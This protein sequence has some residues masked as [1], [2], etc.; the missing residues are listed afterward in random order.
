MQIRVREDSVEIEGYVN[1]VERNSKPLWSRI[2]Q[3]IERICAGAFKK[4]MERREDVHILLNHDP[5]RDLGSVA[6]GNLELEEDNIG[7]R[8]RATITDAEVVEEARNG[9]LVGWSFG[10][11]DVPDGVDESMR[12]PETNLPMRVVRDLDLQ[13]VSILDRR[14]TPAYN[15]TLIMARAEDAPVYYGEEQEEDPEI[16]EERA[17]SAAEDVKPEDAPEDIDYTKWDAMIAEMK[18]DQIHE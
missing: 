1:A 18:G 17:E 7:L 11:L 13:E 8:A 12:D 16:I 5:E 10:F 9:D 4:S 15:G 14:K 6:Q 2:G 3:F